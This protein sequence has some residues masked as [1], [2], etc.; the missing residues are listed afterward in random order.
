[1]YEDISGKAE[2]ACQAEAHQTS[3]PTVEH[4]SQSHQACHHEIKSSCGTWFPRAPLLSTFRRHGYFLKM[5]APE[6]QAQHTYSQTTAPNKGPSIPQQSSTRNVLQTSTDFGT[7]C[8]DGIWFPRSPN[9]KLS[10]GSRSPS[11]TCRDQAITRA[12]ELRAAQWVALQSHTANGGLSL[13][14]GPGMNCPRM[15][16]R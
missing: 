7:G 6:K 13:Q 12:V 4:G 15:V 9:P 14:F 8:P 1:M 3:T 2:F 5:A 16:Q 11:D 10:E